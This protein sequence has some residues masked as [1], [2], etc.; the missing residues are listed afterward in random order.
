MKKTILAVALAAASTFAS[1]SEGLTK[2]SPAYAGSKVGFS[3]SSAKH[4][5]SHNAGIQVGNGIVAGTFNYSDIEDFTTLNLGLK[6]N[7]DG[8]FGGLNYDID[9]DFHYSYRN[10]YYSESLDPKLGFHLGYE[11]NP[12]LYVMW[13]RSALEW[14]YV[15]SNL[16]G[17]LE[18]VVNNLVVGTQFQLAD[19]LYGHGIFG[20]SM[21]SEDSKYGYSYTDNSAIIGFGIEYLA[22]SGFYAGANLTHVDESTVSFGFGYMF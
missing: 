19:N 13:A 21:Y 4:L 10:S 5:D 22:N 20:M 7:A 3:A 12:N 16:R 14:N 2:F 17:H 18:F 15:D 8:F 9:S 6:F 1:A 11:F